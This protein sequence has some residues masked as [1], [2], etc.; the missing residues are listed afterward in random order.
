MSTENVE[1]PH[2]FPPS[3]MLYPISELV[4]YNK[5]VNISKC[6]SEFCQ[7]LQQTEEG[8]MGTSDLTCTCYWCLKRVGGGVL[9]DWD[10]SG[11]WHY[12]Q[13]NSV[14]TE[15]NCRTPQT[16]AAETGKMLGGVCKKHTGKTET[17]ILFFFYRRRNWGSREFKWLVQG[18]TTLK[19]QNGDSNLDFPHLYHVDF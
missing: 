13:V 6:F 3:Y 10:Y 15:L 5:P 7:P 19:C 4:F 9:L 17:K 1:T 18:S 16:V 11:I 12:L 8:L 14:R 2:S